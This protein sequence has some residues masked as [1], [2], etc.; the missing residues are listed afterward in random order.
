M[1]YHVT[2]T[3]KKQF[4]KE[5]NP[6]NVTCVMLIL[7]KKT[8]FEATYY[9]QFTKEKTIQMIPNPRTCHANFTKKHSLKCH[10]TSTHKKTIHEGKKSFKCVLKCDLCHTNFTQKQSLKQ[11][12]TNCVFL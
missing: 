5:R 1:K 3:H 6:L 7:H 9:K 12:I 8:Q 2:S 10:V 11:H 4:T